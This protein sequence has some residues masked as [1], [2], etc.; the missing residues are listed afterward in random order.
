MPLP[1]CAP[2]DIRRKLDLPTGTLDPDER[3]RFGA[4][5]A[6]ASQ[7]WDTTTGSPLRTVRKG[8]TEAPQTWEYADAHGL[9][10]GP[11]VLINLAHDEINPI[12]SAQ[13]DRIEVRTGRDNFTDVTDEEGDE[14]AV[15]YR[16]GQLKLYRFLLN[17]L[18]F[19]SQDERLVRLTYRHGGLGG[20]RESGATT[21]LTSSVGPTDTMF[22][23]ADAARLPPSPLTVLVGDG[24]AESEYVRV[25]DI[26]RQTDTLT[27]S[28]ATRQTD[29]RLHDAGAGVQY[30]PVDVREAVAAKAAET[31][32]LD[33]DAQLSI[34]DDGQLTNRT[35]RADR[36]R[37]EWESATAQYQSV[38]TL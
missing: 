15:V 21:E 35:N 3:D 37:D 22:S 13:G 2:Q 24:P 10:R 36:F 34:P 19:E 33:D 11:P 12:D 8:A 16:D 29:V 9:R 32:T 7:R 6:A 26:D 5:A 27:V 31:L 30:T 28:R 20:D 25:T 1:Y 17:R 14:Y 23:V 4:R 18:Q 38:R